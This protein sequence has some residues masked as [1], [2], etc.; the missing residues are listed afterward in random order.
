MKEIILKEYFKNLNL[1]KNEEELNNFITFL[2]LYTEEKNNIIIIRKEKINSFLKEDLMTK[3]PEKLVK[4]DIENSLN[5]EQKEIIK[6]SL[7]YKKETIKFIDEFVEEVVRIG[8]NNK[9]L[10]S[11][12]EQIPFKDLKEQIYNEISLDIKTRFLDPLTNTL[13]QNFY[14]TTIIPNPDK[15]RRKEDFEYLNKFIK[16]LYRHNV[17]SIMYIDISNF[18]K[19]N[20]GLSHDSGDKLLKL[21]SKEIL[22]MDPKLFIR[23]G[24]DE[25]IILDNKEKLKEIAKN[26]APFTNFQSKINDFIKNEE[27]RLNKK[28]PKNYKVFLSYGI[29]DIDLKK[30]ISKEISSVKDV[31]NYTNF[32]MLHI[33]KAEEKMKENKKI[34]K[35]QLKSKDSRSHDDVSKN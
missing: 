28:Y 6:T 31:K 11:L 32:F 14:L 27:Q 33:L 13:N 26:I 9:K 34:M 35:K 12:I 20:D 5:K 22:K 2:S 24:G 4:K 8:K 21:I 7:K 10:L 19:V 1:F 29:N 17:N 25:F 3:I 30:F 18:K 16:S 15:N 23:T